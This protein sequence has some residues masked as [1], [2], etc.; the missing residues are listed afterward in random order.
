MTT[1]HLF[2]NNQLYFYTPATEDTGPRVIDAAVKR[3]DGVVIGLY[4]QEDQEQ[5]SEKYPG[6]GLETQDGF[7]KQLVDYHRSPV[8]E[9][10]EES[11][12]RALEVLPP[13]EWVHDSIGESFKMSEH[14]TGPVTNVYARMGKRYFT[15]TDHCDLPHPE[16]MQRVLA[17]VEANK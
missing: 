17:Y 6:I 3:A 14:L 10:D 13:E 12:I 1:R 2:G 4:S 5:L 16:V 8:T 9:I 7:T 15:M 11:F